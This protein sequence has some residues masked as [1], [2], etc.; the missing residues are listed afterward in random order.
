MTAP[1]ARALPDTLPAAGTSPT[2][3]GPIP[4]PPPGSPGSTSRP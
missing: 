1:A 3:T 4:V 2:P